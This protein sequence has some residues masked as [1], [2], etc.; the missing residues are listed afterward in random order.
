MAVPR[1][2]NAE[3]RTKFL[4]RN[5]TWT[6]GRPCIRTNRQGNWQSGERQESQEMGKAFDFHS[7][8]LELPQ[9]AENIPHVRITLPNGAQIFSGQDENSDHTLSK[10]LGRDVKLT[11]ADLEKP[12]YEEYWPNIGPSTKREV[13]RRN[14]AS[15]NFLRYCRNRYLD[16]FYN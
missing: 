6:Y 13:H 11:R 14:N 2:L 1:Q 16:N 3:R 8:F 5:R 4:L 7:V 10:A 12:S 15:P 9:V